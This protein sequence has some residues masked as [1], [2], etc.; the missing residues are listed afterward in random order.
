MRVT[1]NLCSYFIKHAKNNLFVIIQ[2]SIFL[3]FNASLIID[4]ILLFDFFF[5][6][7]QINKLKKSTEHN[8]NINYSKESLLFSIPIL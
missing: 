5:I 8:I 3:N 2:K 1:R 4:I 7:Y 6:K